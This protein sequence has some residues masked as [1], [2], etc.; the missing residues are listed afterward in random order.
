LANFVVPSGDAG[1][2]S[3]SPNPAT[4]VQ[5][6]PT[7]LTASWTGLDAAKRWFGVINYSGTSS[8]TLLS[9]G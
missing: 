5:G 4:V 2:A 1:N 3:V 6:T 8:Y 7:T 9:V